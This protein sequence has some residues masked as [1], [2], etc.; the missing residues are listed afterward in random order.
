MPLLN[1]RLARPKHLIDINGLKDQA[2]IR[3]EAD[4][5]LT[6][7]AL[8][9]Q[10]TVEM[11]PLVA[12]HAPMAADAVPLIADRQVR[13]RGT[14]GG[15]LVHADPS[16]ELPTLV[17]V[18]DA[19]L[20]LERQGSSRMVLGRDFFLSPLITIAEPDELLTEIRIP[21][22]AP[23]SGQAFLELARQHG[24]FAIASAAAVLTLDDGHIGQ[25]R[26]CLGGVGPGPL[27]ADRAEERLAGEAPSP[28]LFAEAARLAAEDTD[29]SGDIHGSAEYRRHVAEVYARRALDLA[30]QR[31]G[32]RSL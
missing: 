15:S 11:S 28:S 21:A 17:A 23:Q 4:G 3:R 14:V 20:K 30:Y 25:A 29:P 5:S 16:A 1:M 27:R 13:F 24:A 7:G 32:G 18:L 26:L 31:A 2:Y 22:S 9:R 12:E 6:I 19:E 8:T 10:R